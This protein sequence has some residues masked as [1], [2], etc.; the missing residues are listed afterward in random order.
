MIET[1]TEKKQ[2]RQIAH[3]VAKL[4]VTDVLIVLL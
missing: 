4:L 1:K 2:Q 3:S